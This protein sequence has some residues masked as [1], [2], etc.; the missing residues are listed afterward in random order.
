[1]TLYLELLKE[2]R[3]GDLSLGDRPVSIAAIRETFPE[4]G[5]RRWKDWRNRAGCPARAQRISRLSALKLWLI[6]G[7]KGKASDEAVISEI[8][9]LTQGRATEL[10]QWLDSMRWEA[11]TSATVM[12]SLNAIAPDLDVIHR[13][14][15]YEWWERAG[16]RFSASQKYSH[17]QIARAASV[18]RKG[19]GRG[20]PRQLAFF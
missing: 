17:A 8:S 12:D 2:H 14:R 16:M 3:R 10:R 7:S 15:L 11:E 6:A 18:A 5:W 1:M 9:R 4:V 20:R 19:K 13:Q